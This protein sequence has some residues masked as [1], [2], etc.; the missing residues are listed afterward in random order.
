MK[1]KLGGKWWNYIRVRLTKARGYCDP[2]NSV[3][4]T[5]RVDSRL[6]GEEELEVDLHEMTHAQGWHIDEEFVTRFAK[7]T[8]RALTRLGYKK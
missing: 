3:G 8:A 4:K 2:P 5:I 7:E 1:I 6:K